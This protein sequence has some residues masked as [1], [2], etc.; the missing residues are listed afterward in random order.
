MIASPLVLWTEAGHRR[1]LDLSRY[2]VLWTQ[3]ELVQSRKGGHLRAISVL[4]TLTKHRRLMG[5]R[6]PAIIQSR[7]L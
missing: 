6:A 1:L 7:F 4:Y 3:R 2:K 5:V